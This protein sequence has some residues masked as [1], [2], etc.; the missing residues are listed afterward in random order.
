M[1]ATRTDPADVF[2]DAEAIAEHFEVGRTKAYELLAVEGFPAS[3]VPGM[4]RI[5]LAAIRRWVMTTSTG[6]PAAPPPSTG[7]SPAGPDRP[8]PQP[9]PAR[10]PGRPRRHH[11]DPK[12]KT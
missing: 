4:V 2:L 8:A 9:P 11:E 1:N 5:P 3:V 7:D 12:E 6:T 10:R